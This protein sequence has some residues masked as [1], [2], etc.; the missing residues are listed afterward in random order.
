MKKAYI[1]FAAVVVALVLTVAALADVPNLLNY[2]GRLT[3]PSGNPK[4][5]TFTMQF[6][7]YDAESGGNQL[8]SGSP[9]SETQSVT[10]TN[11][12]FN[13]LLGSVTALPTN[14]FEG[15]PSDASGPLRFLQVTVS[16]EA[17]APRRRISSAAYS[18]NGP[19]VPADA[20]VF[21][22]TLTLSGFEVSSDPLP[23]DSNVF[24]LVLD[25]AF[26]GYVAPD[27]YGGYLKFNH[28]SS[29][30]YSS[31]AVLNFNPPSLVRGTSGPFQLGAC[32]TF[33]RVLFRRTPG[34]NGISV[35]FNL[36][37]SSPSETPLYGWYV[38]GGTTPVN[39]FQ[40]SGGVSGSPMSG[41]VHVFK[42]SRQ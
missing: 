25:G 37:G 1:P 35:T 34:R 10:V 24:M 30:A 41:K 4:N 26:F 27:C 17:L 22:E 15:G 42:L 8:P 20:W 31:T 40:I 21:V 39:A 5:G 19:A 23:M 13:V 33:G 7:V 36:D 9:W 16:G 2:Q 18:M 28:D 29:L 32:D 3:D 6:A 11:G 12:V 14:L 38:S